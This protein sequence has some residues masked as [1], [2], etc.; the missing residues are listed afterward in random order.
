[1]YIFPHTHPKVTFFKKQVFRLPSISY[2]SVSI[3]S[4]CC[5]LMI[6]RTDDTVCALWDLT[7]PKQV[8]KECVWGHPQVQTCEVHPRVR[9]R[10]TQKRI[11]NKCLQ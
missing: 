7:K 8:L 11:L 5:A 1:M 9:G 4:E 6:Y 10:R 2:L 3:F